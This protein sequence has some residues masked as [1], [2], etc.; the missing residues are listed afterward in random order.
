MDNIIR[1]S[2]SRLSDE[3][4]RPRS[5][6]TT[7][8]KGTANLARLAVAHDSFPLENFGCEPLQPR[9]SFR[10]TQTHTASTAVREAP[11]NVLLI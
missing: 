6:V 10:N 2:S 4:D 11:V 1:P 3:Y 7:I 5:R 9:R 8:D